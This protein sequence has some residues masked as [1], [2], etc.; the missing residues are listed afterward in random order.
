[1]RNPMRIGRLSCPGRRRWAVVVVA[2]LAVVGV[3]AV[4]QAGALA[5]PGRAGQGLGSI[6]CPAPGMCM[7]TG[8]SSAT[9]SPYV[10]RWNGSSWKATPIGAISGATL[11]V[12][13]VSCTSSKL[14]EAVGSTSQAN[15]NSLVE[16]WNGSSW[17]RVPSPNEPNGGGVLDSVA[18]PQATE[19]WAVGSYG[20]GELTERFIER[21]NGSA[22][23]IAVP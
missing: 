13:G 8:G 19:C 15:A 20:R 17:A 10:A 3:P 12:N 7:A 16:Q 2:T 9:N 18:C 4:S 6:S 23:T 14:C 21:W 22:W 11:N 5:S 1:M